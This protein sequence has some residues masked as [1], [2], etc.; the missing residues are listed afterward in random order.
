VFEVGRDASLTTAGQ[1]SSDSADAGRGTIASVTLAVTHDQ[2]RNLAEARRTG[3]L[4][5]LLLPPSD[6]AE[7]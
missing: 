2:A 6:G 4:D 7:Q 5:V 3:D 1:S